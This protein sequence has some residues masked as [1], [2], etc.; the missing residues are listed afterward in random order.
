MGTPPRRV[1]SMVCQRPSW[2]RGPLPGIN[3]KFEVELWNFENYQDCIVI[4]LTFCKH[5]V[6][7]RGNEPACE[8][9][10][11]WTTGGCPTDLC[12]SRSVAAKRRWQSGVW[13]AHLIRPVAVS[14]EELNLTSG[15]E[16]SHHFSAGGCFVVTSLSYV[17][18]YSTFFRS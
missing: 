5:Q 15:G 13:C 17:R 3:H 6:T 4:H 1:W 11:E 10:R 14:H 12:Y 2:S 8:S 16:G 18:L 9:Q 7:Y